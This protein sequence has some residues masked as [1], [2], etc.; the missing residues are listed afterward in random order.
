MSCL[1]NIAH[2]HAQLSVGIRRYHLHPLK[3]QR[4]GMFEFCL[5]GGF[6]LFLGLFLCPGGILGVMYALHPDQIVAFL[7]KADIR[8]SLRYMLR[9]ANFP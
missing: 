6:Q 8:T 3:L 4:E 9:N 5:K 1:F 2:D 7:N